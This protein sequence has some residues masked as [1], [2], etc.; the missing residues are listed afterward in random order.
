[1]ALSLLV[2]VAIIIRWYQLPSRLFFGFEQGRDAQII[3][4]IA[5]LRDFVLVGPKTDLN[6]IFHGAW[7]YYLMVLP[8]VIGNG[9]PL[10]LAGFLVLASSFVP[11]IM[12]LL[13]SDITTKRVWGLVAGGLSV[14]SFEL[15]SYSRWLS[16]VTLAVPVMAICLWAVW[17]LHITKAS[18]YWIL[19][20]FTA[21]LAA[22][23]EI[24]LCIWLAV[25]LLTLVLLRILPWPNIKT[26]VGITLIV[27]G[28]FL[29]MLLFNIRNEFITI[30]SVVAYPEAQSSTEAVSW[31]SRFSSYGELMERLAKKSLWYLPSWLI[32]I[33]TL[34][35]VWAGTQLRSQRLRSAFIIL[36]LWTVMS[37]PVLF[38]PHSLRLTQLYVGSALGYIGLAVLALYYFSQ[39]KY[40]KIVLIV[41]TLMLGVSIGQMLT[42]LHLNQDVFYTTIQDDLN[43]QDQQAL[44][45]YVNTEA[46]GEP[47]RLKAFTIP[48]YQEEGWQYLHG[49]HY[50]LHTDEAAKQIFV[51]IEEKVDPYWEKTWIQELGATT[52]L[53]EQQF[54]RLRVQK[55]A[56]Q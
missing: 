13:F 54:G 51:I 28:L 18:R 42:R 37:W 44:L 11:M 46:A 24:I 22:Q 16:N 25:Y 40:G 35:I 55:R 17:K 7:Y 47:Y 45:K 3:Q 38:F 1:M 43:Y 49:Y 33:L 50:P 48:Y 9:S 12:A 6:G 15:V 23:F 8:F 20:A 52:L 2:V 30:Q 27:F 4:N 5:A 19:I 41:S 36:G 34:A 14:V 31:I 21:A 39:L 56:I 26:W 53:D 10:V 29:P 32:I